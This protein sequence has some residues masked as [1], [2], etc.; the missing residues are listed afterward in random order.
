M[1]NHIR[2]LPTSPLHHWGLCT[3]PTFNSAH[4]HPPGPFF[5]VLLNPLRLSCLTSSRS[6]IFSSLVGSTPFKLSF[7]ILH[8]LSALA[9]FIK[10][11]LGCIRLGYE[12]YP[13]RFGGI[14]N[15]DPSVSNL[16]LLHFD[17][18]LF[19]FTK[20]QKIMFIL[21]NQSP[22]VL[23]IIRLFLKLNWLICN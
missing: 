19:F 2:L 8:S 1:F 13:K 4:Y 14:I 23:N 6:H 16:N 22:Q 20:W 11:A 3:A 17:I 18:F 10:F 12:Q 15:W 21:L 9:C 5:Q 7:R